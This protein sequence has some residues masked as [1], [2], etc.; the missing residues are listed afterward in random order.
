MKKIFLITLSFLYITNAFA[1]TVSGKI[2]DEKNEPVPFANVYL[3]GT[4]RGT[5]S[6]IE[7]AYSLDLAP[8]T[9]ELV[10]KLI[11]YKL[12]IENITISNSAQIINVKLSPESFQLKT[13][14]VKADGEDPAYAVIRQAQ[15]KRKFYLEQVDAYSCDVYIKGVQRILKAPKKIMG[16]SVDFGDD[17]DSASG[18]VYLSESVSKFNFKQKDK[19]KEE[20]VSSKVSGN[21]KAFSYNQASDMLFNFYENIIEVDE[22]SERGFISP[23]ANTALLNYRYKLLG[24]FFE[25]GLMINKIQVIPKRKNDPVFSGIINVM[26]NSWRIHSLELILTKDAQIDFVDTLRINQI[27]IPVEKEIWL[28]FSTKYVFDFGVLGIK[29]DGMYV[30]VNSNYVIDPDFP[31]HYFTNEVMKVN[32]DANKKDSAYW[33]VS[34]PVP[35]TKE[36]ADDYHRRDSIARIKSTKVYTDSTDKI[37]NKL[38]FQDL[39]FG[40]NHVNT[41]KKQSW[42]ISGPLM[43]TQFN[44]VQGFNLSTTFTYLKR[45]EN[46]KNYSLGL[47]VGYGFSNEDVYGSIYGSYTYKPQKFATFYLSAGRTY[48]QFNNNGKI[49]P[50]L[51]SLYSLLNEQNFMKLYLE[52]SIKLTHTSELFNGFYFTPSAK[53][54]ERSPLINTTGFKWVKSDNVYTSND[55]Q[56]PDSAGYSFQS[57]RALTAEAKIKY[58]FKQRY[59][60]MPNIKMVTGSKFPALLIGYKKGIYALDSKIN[61]DLLTLGLEGS[62]NLKRFG[63]SDY[64]I[65]AGSFL[66]NRKM[67]FMDWYHFN[68]NQTLYSDFEK[69]SF[70]LLEYYSASTQS[71][72]IEGHFEHN[73]GGFFLSK[74]PLIKKLKLNEVGKVSLL[75]TDGK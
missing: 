24:T 50:L 15:K 21:N 42:S 17:I 46:R 61:F 19:I 4:T 65:T 10:F 1:F 70:Q 56:N 40:Y 73:F 44:T 8:G 13:A 18:I 60:T 9:Y 14:E 26:E 7:G 33:E 66:N 6:N 75:T 62:F 63:N 2:T 69:N 36:E 23:I 47:N 45:F 5:T 48:E 31:K 22:L 54:A 35:L 12:H 74:V 57:H 43:S 55:P 72:F 39:I 29:G 71:H 52:Q 41:F 38:K 68:G 28:P 53:Y 25:D 3:K 37:K 59:Y 27:F 20:M 49:H 34:R 16:V 30:G 67:Y 58:I 32:D 64:S 51:N 11:G